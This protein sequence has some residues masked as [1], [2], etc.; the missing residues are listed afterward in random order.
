MSVSKCCSFL[1]RAEVWWLQ[2]RSPIIH[3]CVSTLEYGGSKTEGKRVCYSYRPIK[4][5]VCTNRV[6]GQ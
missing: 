1:E 3:L 4:R 5:F 6:I 2:N